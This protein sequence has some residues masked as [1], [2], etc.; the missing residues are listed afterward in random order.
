MSEIAN[1]VVQRL[2]K[3][4]ADIQAAMV[5]NNINASGRTSASLAVVEYEGGAKLVAGAG[6]RAPLPTLEIGREGGRVPKGFYQILVQWSIDKGIA[7]SSERERH[8]FAYFLGKKIAREGTARHAV[9]V[10]VY[11]TLTQQ[12]ADEIGGMILAEVKELIKSN[13]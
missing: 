2:E 12:A 9:H 3:L 5:A 7:F 1:N 6:N 13:I 8:T 11:S 4:K 10:D